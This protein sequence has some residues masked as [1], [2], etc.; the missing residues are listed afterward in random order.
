MLLEDRIQITE[1]VVLWVQAAVGDMLMAVEG[2]A[3]EGPIRMAATST[4]TS[5][6]LTIPGT[7]ITEEEGVGV[8]MGTTT[9]MPVKLAML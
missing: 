4:M 9:I 6:V 7:T 1:V 5:L 8:S 3:G 2:A